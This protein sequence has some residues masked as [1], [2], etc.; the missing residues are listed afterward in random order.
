MTEQ[1]KDRFY[2]SGAWKRARLA[3]LR[4]DR[5]KCQ[6][7][8]R[9]IRARQKEN[10]G[11]SQRVPDAQMVHHIRELETHPE[12][13]L[14]LDNLISL[15]SACHNARHPEKLEGR[16]PSQREEKPNPLLAGMNIYKV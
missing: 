11:Y 2:A 5:W 13:A 15:C 4:R 8:L 9:R 3:A 14:T 10:P 6:D 7:C 16:R 1:E 12:L